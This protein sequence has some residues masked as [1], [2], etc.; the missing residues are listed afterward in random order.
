MV[1]MGNEEVY[2]NKMTRTPT[3]NISINS[4]WTTGFNGNHRI[5]AL[6]ILGQKRVKASGMDKYIKINTL[7]PMS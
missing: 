6:R 3:E 7:P 2:T 1:F 5:L 4:D